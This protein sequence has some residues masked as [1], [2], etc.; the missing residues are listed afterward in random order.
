MK[1]STAGRL[2]LSRRQCIVAATTVLAVGLNRTLAT[3]QDGGSVFAFSRSGRFT[4]MV[5]GPVLLGGFVV[6][7]ATEAEIEA[8]L[9][10]RARDVGFGVPLTY[11]TNRQNPVYLRQALDV[12]SGYPV[13]F[14][15]ATI[16]VEGWQAEADAVS[17]LR[18]E[19]EAAFL[20]D[21]LELT[22]VELASVRHARQ[23]D[24]E[25]YAALEQQLGMAPTRF[26]DSHDDSPRLYQVASTVVKCFG[27]L[28]GQR[29]VGGAKRDM[30]DAVL[31]FFGVDEQPT[32]WHTD[33]L[34]I[35]NVVVNL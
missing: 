25:I 27:S 26:Y 33:R 31:G 35:D 3:A 11:G 17:A 6:P 20:S 4:P 16:D 24:D 2:S 14:V 5:L 7:K 21:A 10:Q 15:G 1:T 19:A 13:A 22:S 28:Y 9:E 8:T 12:L 32:S 23:Q 30:V 34:Q 18:Q 29:P